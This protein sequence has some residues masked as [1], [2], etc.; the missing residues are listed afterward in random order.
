MITKKEQIEEVKGNEEFSNEEIK[1]FSRD[2]F[3]CKSTANTKSQT[4]CWPVGN[5]YFSCDN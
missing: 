4:D 5:C 3:T 2:H 1:A